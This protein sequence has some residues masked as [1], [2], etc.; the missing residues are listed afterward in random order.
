MFG[1]YMF[2]NCE[3]LVQLAHSS[4]IFSQEKTIYYGKA[5][6]HICPAH[7]KTCTKPSSYYFCCIPSSQQT[8]PSAATTRLHHRHSCML[9]PCD[10]G[11]RDP[12]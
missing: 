4:C 5:V 2:L 3:Y 9:P 7:L 12:G 10:H 6:P 1:F 8:P 11:N